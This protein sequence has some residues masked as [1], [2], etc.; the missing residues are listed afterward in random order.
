MPVSQIVNVKEA[1][2]KDIET[3]PPVNTWMIKKQNSLIA[4]MEKV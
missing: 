1:F 4:A 2:L 3:D